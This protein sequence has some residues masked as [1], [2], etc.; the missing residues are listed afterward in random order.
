MVIELE[1]INKRVK[2]VRKKLNLSQEEFGNKIGLSKSGIS[3]IEK[4]TRNVTSKHVKLI[5][6]IF[7]VNELWL[8]TGIDDSEHLKSIEREYAHFNSFIKYLNSLGYTVEVEKTGESSTGHYED[9]TDNT[10]AVVGQAWIPDEEFFSIV[11]NNGKNK[12][13]FTSEEFQELQTNVE[14]LIS[15]ELFKHTSK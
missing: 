11:I 5:C 9:Q 8:T 6:T 1:S 2:E 10:G 12:Q 13:I 3:N 15:F 7:N 14:H 4:G